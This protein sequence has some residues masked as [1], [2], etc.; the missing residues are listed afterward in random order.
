MKEKVGGLEEAEGIWQGR[1][2]TGDKS[3]AESEEQ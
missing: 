2:V 1:A 3:H